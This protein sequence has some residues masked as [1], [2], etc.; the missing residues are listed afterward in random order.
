VAELTKKVMGDMSEIVL[1]SGKRVR[2]D[3]DIVSYP[4]RYYDE[5]AGDMFA[6]VMQLAQEEE[7][8]EAA[9]LAACGANPE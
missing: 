5:N 4:D 6:K 1:G 3:A 9:Y 2:V 8:K 7:A